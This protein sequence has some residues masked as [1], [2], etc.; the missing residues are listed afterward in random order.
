MNDE[1][2][3]MLSYNESTG[4]F[5]NPEAKGESELI[6]NWETDEYED[7]NNYEDGEVPSFLLASYIPPPQELTELICDVTRQNLL[8]L[9]IL[10]DVK[11]TE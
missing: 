9:G 2:F 10:K 6:Y 5:E 8:R 11:P 4:E 3:L 1:D 7:P